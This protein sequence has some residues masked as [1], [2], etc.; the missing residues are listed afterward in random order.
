MGQQEHF[1]YMI[2]LGEFYILSFAF[3]S[4]YLQQFLFSVR[5]EIQHT[6]GG[7]QAMAEKTVPCIADS[8]TYDWLL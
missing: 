3:K 4:H 6:L 1:L 2:L 5:A 8:I 7:L